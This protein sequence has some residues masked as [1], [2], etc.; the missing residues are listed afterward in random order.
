MSMARDEGALVVS[1]EE[2]EEEEAE[3]ASLT[4]VADP[5]EGPPK[6]RGGKFSRLESRGP[7]VFLDP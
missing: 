2:E 6:L 5:D 1:K 7:N 3:E 4:P